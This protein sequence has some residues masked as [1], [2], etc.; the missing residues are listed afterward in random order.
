M[1]EARPVNVHATAIALS[2]RGILIRGRSGSGKSALALSTLR[3]ADALGLEAAL[4]ADD[5]VL[6]ERNGEHVDALAPEAIRGLIEVAGVGILPERSIAR[7]RLELLVDLV[8]PGEIPRM[9][10]SAAAGILG[11]TLR[12]IVLP[13]RQA[14]FGA[15]VLHSLMRSRPAMPS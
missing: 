15:D 14:A 6:V 2:G 10:D 9:P 3:R 5:Q 11:V 7:I 12:R 8:A 13:E 4:V 1:N